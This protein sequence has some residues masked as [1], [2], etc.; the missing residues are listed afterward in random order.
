MAISADITGVILAAGK[1]GRM[2]TF[3]PLL[4]Y[5]GKTFLA[6]ITS[7]LLSV[8]ESTVIV[9]GAFAERLPDNATLLAACSIGETSFSRLRMVHNPQ[10]E[11]GMM[12]SIRTAAALVTSEWMLA[13]FIDQPH[14]PEQF[15]VEFADIIAL[16]CNW[17]QPSYDG[18]G[19]HP[20]AIHRT[21]FPALLQREGL[22][23]LRD[24]RS[25]AEVNVNY[26]SC[27]YP[28]VRE[29]FDT[30]EEYARLLGQKPI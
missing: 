22:A 26:W 13:H 5:N 7:K 24:L 8:C 1:S 30:P 6:Q 29:D 15:Y 11:T 19:G 17:V 25:L 16:P 20:I 21:L 18:R 23:S 10:H 12:S 9:S 28:E 4:P 3:K 27:S 2:R 14:I